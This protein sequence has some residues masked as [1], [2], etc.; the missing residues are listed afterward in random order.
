MIRIPKTPETPWIRVWG[1]L[2]D[3]IDH[4]LDGASVEWVKET[5]ME[6]ATTDELKD[7]GIW[8]WLGFEEDDDGE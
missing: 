7:L 3:Y 2:V 1:I 4:D 5:L 6:I 8:E